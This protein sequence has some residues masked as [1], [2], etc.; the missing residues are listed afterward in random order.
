[1]DFHRSY[2][3]KVIFFQNKIGI[4]GDFGSI[5]TSDAINS[6]FK[7]PPIS[8]EVLITSFV[9]ETVI[10]ATTTNNIGVAWQGGKI[11]VTGKTEF[12]DWRIT[13]RDDHKSQV[14]NYFNK[15][16]KETYHHKI[17]NTEKIKKYKRS[18]YV[19]LLG[20]GSNMYSGARTYL[21]SGIWPKSIGEISLSYGNESIITF[22]VELSMDYME[23]VDNSKVGTDFFNK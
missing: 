8:E 14:F 12:S 6:N 16:K 22:P 3:F 9:S 21:L 20:S 5:V 19:I 1:M 17:G 10:P 13:V 11:K 18:A 7:N 2:L 4:G 15:W 23:I